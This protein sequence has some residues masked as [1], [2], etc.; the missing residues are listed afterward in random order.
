M[1][2]SADC[3][4]TILGELFVLCLWHLL[5]SLMHPGV[6]SR[7]DMIAADEM[8]CA[9]RARAF[10]CPVGM[11]TTVFDAYT[12][13]H[14]ESSPVPAM[15]YPTEPMY[16]MSK[17]KPPSLTSMRDRS[18]DYSTISAALMYSG[19]SN[20]TGQAPSPCCSQV[21]AQNTMQSRLC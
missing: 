13:S 19:W 20:V 11:W 14:N 10:A 4:V 7:I 8:R 3:K 9:R 2:G 1:L 5:I 18:G 16:D 12:V 21:F 6:S 15:I 17:W